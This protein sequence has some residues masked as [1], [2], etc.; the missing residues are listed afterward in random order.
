MNKFRLLVVGFAAAG[1]VAATPVAASAGGSKPAPTPTPV[2][3]STAV[4][5]PFNLD[6]STKKVL[7]ADGGLGLV[8]S[9]ASDGSI[10]PIATDQP[11][12]SGIAVSR[13]GRR[14][15]FT[16]TVIDYSTFTITDSGLNVWGQ[17]G[18]KLYADTL[19][20]E[21]AK[22]PDQSITYGIENPSPCVAEALA[23]AG[24]PASYT[25]LVD[26][27]AYSVAA[28]GRGWVVADAGANALFTV[29][30]KGRVK[31]LAVLPAQPAKITADAA[32]ELGLPDCVVGVTYAFEAVPTDVEVG[33]DG[34]LYVSTLP[35]GPESAALGARGSVYKVNPFTGKAKRVAGGF[36]G[37]TNLALA[38]NGTIYVA[39]LFGGQISQ[40]RHGRTSTLVSLPG[41]VAVETSARG[42]VWA[43]TM[44]S[45]D[46]AAPGTIVRVTGGKVYQKGTVWE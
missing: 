37:A 38:P 24:I 33:R 35:G 12:A 20:Y 34:W 8:G 44:A 26:S 21:T 3:E 45:E 14:T 10:T 28:L 15:A 4:V 46:P 19:A 7:V 29:D 17:G 43:A 42:A 6:L 22:N 2:V 23:A 18:S 9:L 1:L 32:A 5:Q 36:L 16:T 31:T 30:R 11:G 41:V 25:G 39:E 13:D 40:V 27:H